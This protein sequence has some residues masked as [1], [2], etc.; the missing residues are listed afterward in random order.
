MRV[1][2]TIPEAIYYAVQVLNATPKQAQEIRKQLKAR[3]VAKFNGLFL[4]FDD[5]HLLD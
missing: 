5:L 4:F 1:F 2:H 3:S